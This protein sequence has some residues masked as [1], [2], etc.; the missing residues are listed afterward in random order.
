MPSKYWSFDLHDFG[1]QGNHVREKVP[2]HTTDVVPE[3]SSDNDGKFDAHLVGC[4][5]QES[6][7][8]FEQQEHEQP[9]HYDE[10]GHDLPFDLSL[11][12]GI[13]LLDHLLLVCDC[14]HHAQA[15]DGLL[16]QPSL[17]HHHEAKCR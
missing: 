15:G 11:L 2:T 3:D 7:G 13:Y 17:S 8:Y 1:Q 9:P 14:L 10:G 5:V 16:P 4:P 6:D 12:H